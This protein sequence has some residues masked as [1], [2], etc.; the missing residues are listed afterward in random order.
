M[1]PKKMLGKTIEIDG[2]DVDVIYCE[3]NERI[4]F[5]P[6]V[7]GNQEYL[8]RYVSCPQCYMVSFENE[9]NKAIVSRSWCFVQMFSRFSDWNGGKY[10]K[11]NPLGGF[12]IYTS[13]LNPDYGGCE[14][15]RTADGI[16][17][18]GTGQPEWIWVEAEGRL[19]G[20]VEAFLDDVKQKTKDRLAKALNYYPFLS[21]SK[22]M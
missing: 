5:L 7:C 9:I 13:V 16:S 17:L 18:D 11:M 4:A 1:D 19:W 14:V 20:F 8:N 2:K 12:I 10:E 6:Y 15:D 21:C 22:K 3:A